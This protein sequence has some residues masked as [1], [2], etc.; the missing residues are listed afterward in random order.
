MR[1]STSG[2]EDAGAQALTRDGL[3]EAAG[4][5]VFRRGAEYHSL[6]Q[7][8]SLAEYKSVLTAAVS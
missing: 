5:A 7:A 2:S 3:L 6:G 8:L 1:K 4:E